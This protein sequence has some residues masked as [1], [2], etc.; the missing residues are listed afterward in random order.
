M[1]MFSPPTPSYSQAQVPDYSAATREQQ[2]QE[3]QQRANAS[4]A[5]LSL[6]QGPTSLINQ[7]TGYL[8]VTG[9]GSGSGSSNLGSA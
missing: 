2:A 8:G 3:Q 6:T 7:S 5:R 4:R 9:S 1:C